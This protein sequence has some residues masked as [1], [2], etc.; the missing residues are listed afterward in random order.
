MVVNREQLQEV[1]NKANQHARKQSKDSASI[2]YYKKIAKVYVVKTRK[3][4]S[5][6]LFLMNPDNVRNLN[7]MNNIKL[8]MTVFA[9][10]G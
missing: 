5:L 3:K 6:K 1:L 2:Y 9:G 10:T 4:S 7:I 8:M